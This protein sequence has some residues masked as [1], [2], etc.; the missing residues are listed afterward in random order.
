MN[1]PTPVSHI[2]TLTFVGLE[3][4]HLRNTVY[5]RV[6]G[7]DAGPV[8]I[9]RYSILERVG[10]GAR[11][12]VFKAFDNQLDRLVALKVLSARADDHQELL[13]E[14]KALARLSHPNVL[15]VY[16]VGETLDG[17]VFLATEYVKGWT[18]R[19]WFDEQTRGES[20]IVEVICQV[21]LGVQAAHDEGLVHR[22]LKPANILLGRDGRARV[23]DFGLARFDPAALDP[24]ADVPRDGITTTTAGTPG[25]MAP[26]LFLGE[27]ASAASDQYA[28]AVTLH[29][30][31]VGALPG[32]QESERKRGASR[33]V[34][35]AIRRSL[36]EDPAERFESV[37]DFAR[38]LRA[39]SKRSWRRAL[40]WLGGVGAISVAAAALAISDPEGDSE[41]ANELAL[42]E[43]RA[44]LPGDPAAALEAL[45]GAPDLT[46]PALFSTAERALAMGPAGGQYAL[47]DGARVPEI[48]GSLLAFRDADDEP[49]IL[50][51]DRDG[52]AIRT[53]SE[54]GLGKLPVDGLSPAP[55]VPAGVRLG[56]EDAPKLF[57]VDPAAAR[58][59]DGARWHVGISADTSRIARLDRDTGVA[60]VLEPATG[61]VVWSLDGAEREIRTVNIDH[62]G[63][64]VAWVERSGSAFVLD[65]ASGA[66]HELEPPASEVFFEPETGA[67][68]VQ[69]RFSGLF[70][71]NLQ[72]QETV[73]LFPD[74]DSYRDVRVSPD[75]R[76]VAANGPDDQVVVTNLAH[77]LPRKIEGSAFVFS[78]D[79]AQLAVRRE[80][81]VDVHDLSTHDVR[82]F[83]S[84][85]PVE[86]LGF[87][88]AKTLWTVGSD[89]IAR[90]YDLPDTIALR[91]H[92]ER[93]EDIALSADGSV[94]VSIGRDFSVR[95]W[96]VDAG[97]GAEIARLEREPRKVGLDAQS[98]VVALTQLRTDTQLISLDDGHLV[99]N[100]PNSTARPIVGPGGFL[101]GAGK[102]GVWRYASSEIEWLADDVKECDSLTATQ[103]WVA[104]VCHGGETQLH[105]WTGQQHETLPINDRSWGSSLHAWPDAGHIFYIGSREHLISRRANGTLEAV[106]TPKVVS[107]ARPYRVVTASS[108][109]GH[110]LVLGDSEGIYAAWGPEEEPVPLLAVEW[111]PV[112][113]ISG[114]G[115]RVAYSTI[116]NTIVIRERAI[117]KARPELAHALGLSGGE[118]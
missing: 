48:L 34:M 62:Q 45:R 17:Q 110:D 87:S 115:R 108:G 102:E 70:R 8:R 3:R 75:G 98:G 77:S 109:S 116:T 84:S 100:A 47:P 90:W 43:A 71:V 53:L 105:V 16:E 14:A 80:R 67:V 81:G 51:L 73:R 93:V 103:E 39:K 82:S 19:G 25:Y 63:E 96:D 26:E 29:E 35:E 1:H 11:G 22:D 7:G 23:A 57:E 55:L 68:L 69:G 5:R 72:R 27:P 4:S 112:L 65:L 92:S 99:A 104:A 40:P 118:L 106:T 9:G 66:L 78:R 114:D 20:A 24:G 42:L 86:A 117:S 46:D 50:Q 88:D 41:R 95:R 101:V 64:R 54:V 79:G 89:D 30:L 111:A 12:V 21:A 49:A 32:P 113:A 60:S 58:A 38:A 44:A 18:L 85:S 61:E 74:D 97:V 91:G 59:F 56:L 107:D 76:W 37:G 36:S 52:L 33:V 31:L 6:F 83:E 28:L 13:R 94:A 10:V 2:D 15:S